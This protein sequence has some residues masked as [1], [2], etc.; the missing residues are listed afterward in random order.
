VSEAEKSDT[1]YSLVF[2]QRKDRKNVFVYRTINHLFIN[3]KYY[4]RIIKEDYLFKLLIYED[5]EFSV[6]YIDSGYLEG[7]DE[8]Y[9]ELFLC[10]GHAFSVDIEDELSGILDNL[11]LQSDVQIVRIKERD[12]LKVL[13]DVFISYYEISAKD[14]AE[15]LW[16]GLKDNDLKPFL[17]VKDISNSEDWEK[18]IDEAI[19]NCKKFILLMTPGF[20][21]RAQIKH[22]IKLALEYNKQRIDCKDQKLSKK[23]LF[24]KLDDKQTIDFNNSQY[25]TFTKCEELFREVYYRLDEEGWFP[26]EAE[27]DG[28]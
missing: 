7:Y 14:Y 28:E 13:Y 12:T 24:I 23:H 15:H 27:I 11:E 2:F 1:E 8:N 3:K 5:E 26:S 9:A 6:I 20:E 18:I 21:K 10:Q 17:N 19:I 16:Q 22:E 25:L 4:V